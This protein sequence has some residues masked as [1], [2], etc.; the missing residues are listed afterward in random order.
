MRPPYCLYATFRH[1]A[2][3]RRVHSPLN[4]QSHFAPIAKQL[5]LFSTAS[6]LAPF[7]SSFKAL[8]KFAE[9]SDR[10]TDVRLEVALNSQVQT[11]G[12]PA[13]NRA[14]KAKFVALFTGGKVRYNIEGTKLADSR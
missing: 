13:G 8:A 10:R 5:F 4:R 12:G 6:L 9:L 1:R 7:V 11:Q 2:I 3:K 14:A